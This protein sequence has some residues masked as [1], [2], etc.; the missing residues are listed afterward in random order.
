MKYTQE[1]IIN[2]LKIIKE[3]CGEYE[4][5]THC[6][7]ADKTRACLVCE[8]QPSEWQLNDESTEWKALI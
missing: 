6:P 8:Y 3:T 4:E 2:A 7:F 5:C 1:E